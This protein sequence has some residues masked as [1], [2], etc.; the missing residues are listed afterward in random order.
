MN[1]ENSAALKMLGKTETGSKLKKI[2][3]V[4][5]LLSGDI[6]QFGLFSVAPMCAVV[7]VVILVWYRKLHYKRKGIHKKRDD[8]DYENQRGL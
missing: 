7:A 5:N 3:Y 8:V 4:E 6:S 1:G 2:A